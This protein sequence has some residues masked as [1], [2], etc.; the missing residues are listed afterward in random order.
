MCVCN[1]VVIHK[2]NVDANNANVGE[3]VSITRFI[4]SQ[5]STWYNVHVCTAPTQ[6]L[7]VHDIYMADFMHVTCTVDE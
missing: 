5:F 3:L 7:T 6:Y 2:Y 1:I 4:D